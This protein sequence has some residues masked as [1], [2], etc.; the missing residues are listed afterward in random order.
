[1]SVTG[2]G[3]AQDPYKPTNWNEFVEALAKE[4]PSERKYIDCP[5]DAV[6]DMNEQK[7]I[8][9]GQITPTAT[10]IKG[11][12]LIIK[13]LYCNANQLF[14]NNFHY[15]WDIRDLNVNIYD[16]HFINM[17]LTSY[18]QRLDCSSYEGAGPR[19]FRY[20]GCTFTGISSGTTQ[21][22]EGGIF[23]V[24]SYSDWD[25]SYK[26]VLTFNVSPYSRL[27]C[28]FKIVAKNTPLFTTRRY[29]GIWSYFSYINYDG[30]RLHHGVEGNGTA[31][32]P[33]Y[34]N[35]LIEGDM[36]G[37]AIF[38][39]N[40]SLRAVRAKNTVFNINMKGSGP[41]GYGDSANLFNVVLNTDKIELSA[42]PGFITATADQ[43]QDAEYL[44]SKGFPI[45]TRN[46][47]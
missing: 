19:Y 39:N 33:W 43:L 8:G 28:T 23:N 10:S 27:G 2:T 38:E 17:N 3:T 42:R 45:G 31:P 14:Y 11:N 16:L 25:G 34:A 46:G 1:M 22:N 5:K 36:S 12:G 29:G 26:N 13:N 32:W 18:F 21:T 6:W 24:D 30:Y 41:E 4:S 15:D 7:P 47:S 20:Y 40:V 35:C 37:K 9:V 44:R